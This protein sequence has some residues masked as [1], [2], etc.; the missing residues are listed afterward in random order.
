[1]IKIWEKELN[2]PETRER[3]GGN[4][5]HLVGLQ[6]EISGEGKLSQ[7]RKKPFRSWQT[8]E[9]SKKFPREFSTSVGED[10]FFG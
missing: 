6:D 9:F 10:A 5:S 1:M 7:D 3:I 2:P 8:Q 4:C